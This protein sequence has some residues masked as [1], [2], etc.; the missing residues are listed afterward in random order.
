MDLDPVAPH[1]PLQWFYHIYRAS[2]GIVSRR[3]YGVKILR[4]VKEVLRPR[5]TLDE[6]S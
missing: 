3:Q 6:M 2:S 5:S 1:P 4:R